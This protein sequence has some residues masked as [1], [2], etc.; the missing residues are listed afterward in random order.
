MDLGIPGW[1]IW[2]LAVGLIA[3]LSHSLALWLE[4]RGWL[5]YVNSKRTSR[6]SLAIAAAFDPAARRVLE[7]QEQETREEVDPGDPPSP[8]WRRNLQP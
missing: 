8:G 2:L 5:Y 1:I 6:V 3:A 4:R 7:I